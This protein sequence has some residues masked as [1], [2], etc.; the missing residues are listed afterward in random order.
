MAYT[1]GTCLDRG[2]EMSRAFDVIV[3]GATGFTGELVAEYLLDQYG[4]GG[5][6]SW[7]IGGRNEAKLGGVRDRLAGGAAG[8][9]IIV[10]DSDD[11]EFLG[12]L[13]A[14]TCVVCTTVGPYALYGSKLVAAWRRFFS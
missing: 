9:P 12:K 2:N 7:A 8:L 13:A 5:E 10:G 14:R 6:L 1:T 11:D 4:V 3:W